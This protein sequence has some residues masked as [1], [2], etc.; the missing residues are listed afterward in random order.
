LAIRQQAF[1]P[2]ASSDRRG[3][4][5]HIATWRR[6]AWSQAVASAARPRRS[7]PRSATSVTFSKISLSGCVASAVTVP[8]ACKVKPAG[9]DRNAPKDFLLGLSK[10]AI[11]PI[12]RGTHRVMSW[13]SRASAA[14]EQPHSVVEAISE[15]LNSI[16]RRR[17]LLQTQSQAEFR[18]IFTDFSDDRGVRIGKLEFVHCRRRAFHEQS[19]GKLRASAAES[20]L[21]VRGLSQRGQTVHV[22]ALGA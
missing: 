10:Q 20:C 11:A 4:R 2:T 16:K 22:F 17:G 13:Q 21:A 18:P 6:R 15:P 1:S 14:H 19:A 9:E 7:Q 5:I 8:A 12:E 3:R